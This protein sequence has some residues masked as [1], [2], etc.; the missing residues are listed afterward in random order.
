MANAGNDGQPRAVS[1]PLGDSDARPKIVQ[2]DEESDTLWI[3]N[4][5]PVPN[6]MD[7]FDGC[8]VFSNV[9]RRVNG[10]MIEDARDLL[11]NALLGE[12]KHPWPEKTN[13]LSSTDEA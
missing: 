10:I 5:G 1:V 12:G 11:L 4:G 7:V 2:Y 9:D 8:V 6:G 3:G 13:G